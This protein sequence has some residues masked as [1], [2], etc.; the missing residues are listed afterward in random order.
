MHR[1]TLFVSIA[2]VTAGCGDDTGGSGGSAGTGGAAGTGGEAATTAASTGSGDGGSDATT[3][4]TSTTGA[5]GGDFQSL[6]DACDELDATLAPL[7]D[8][9]ACATPYTDQDCTEIPG[10]YPG[11]EAETEAWF[12]CWSAEATA[13]D[14]ACDDDDRTVC[15]SPAACQSE[16]DDFTACAF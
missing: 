8:E 3:A 2:L 12:E 11:C 7:G 6:I 10:T 15:S 4:A 14:C 5:G 9:A 13:A 16:Y 1:L